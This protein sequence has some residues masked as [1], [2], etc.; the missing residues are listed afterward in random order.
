MEFLLAFSMVPFPAVI[1]CRVFSSD[2]IGFDEGVE[3]KSC[4]LLLV[5]M[6]GL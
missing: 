5:G 2:W 6:G 3:R 1:L 4:D